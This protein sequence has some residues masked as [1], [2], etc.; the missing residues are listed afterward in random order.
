MGEKLLLDRLDLHDRQVL[1]DQ[2]YPKSHLNVDAV[3]HQGNRLL[4][5]REQPAVF[6]FIRQDRFIDRLQQARP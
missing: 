1:N 6:Q 2:V 5:R 3:I 4:T